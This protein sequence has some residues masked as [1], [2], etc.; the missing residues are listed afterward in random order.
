MNDGDNTPQRSTAD[1]AY[2][3][4]IQADPKSQE[5]WRR[6]QAR[7]RMFGEALRILMADSYDGDDDEIKSL[8]RE[9]HDIDVEWEKQTGRPCPTNLDEWKELAAESG[10]PFE[11]VQKATLGDLEP[12]IKGYLKHLVNAERLRVG[13]TS[14]SG[15]RPK[16]TVNARML[17]VVQQ[18]QD[19]IGWNTTKWAK[20]L[21]CAK[22]TIV[23]T[24]AWN[25]YRTLR[26]KNKAE[27]ALDRH[28]R[29]T[30]GQRDRD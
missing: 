14:R 1:E 15:K 11:Y 4:A 21:K 9:W 16:P 8:R 17:E 28:G 29:N 18:D 27:Q 25:L 2:L 10:I 22:S 5:A 7:L 6:A 13:S 3:K 23:D 26:E 30:F 24:D 12:T 19:A 20:H